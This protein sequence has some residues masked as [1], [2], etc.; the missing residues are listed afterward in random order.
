M[1]LTKRTFSEQWVQSS[2]RKFPFPYSNQFWVGRLLIFFCCSLWWTGEVLWR[3]YWSTANRMFWSI[4]TGYQGFQ[5]LLPLIY[6]NTI[7]SLGW[8]GN[9]LIWCANQNS[10]M[11]NNKSHSHLWLK[12]STVQISCNLLQP[13]LGRVGEGNIV[14]FSLHY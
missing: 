4:W 12:L 7:K 10:V 9:S 2:E 8:T 14:H 1:I 13:S 5:W 6:T 11:I 3:D